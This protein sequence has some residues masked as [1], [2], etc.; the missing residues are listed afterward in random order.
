MLM[1]SG[2]LLTGVPKSEELTLMEQRDPPWQALQDGSLLEQMLRKD[3]GGGRLVLGRCPVALQWE[4]HFRA[5]A[6]TRCV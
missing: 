3:E 5:D 4:A 1:S 6:E 2:W